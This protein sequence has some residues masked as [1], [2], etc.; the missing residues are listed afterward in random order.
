M[1]PHGLLSTSLGLWDEPDDDLTSGSNVDKNVR[2]ESRLLV[3]KTFLYCLG[4]PEELSLTIH[5]EPNFASVY[6]VIVTYWYY[7][8]GC[9]PA[10]QISRHV[11]SSVIEEEKLKYLARLWET[12]PRMDNSSRAFAYAG[13]A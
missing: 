4:W 8:Q 13:I 3:P 5:H 2:L 7:G 9:G 10:V 12:Y 6:T 11:V 1:F